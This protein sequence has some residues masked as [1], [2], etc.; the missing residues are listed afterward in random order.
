MSNRGRPRIELQLDRAAALVSKIGVGAA[1]EQLGVSRKTL[2]KCLDAAGFISAPI[3]T[4]KKKPE[5]STEKCDP[6][7]SCFECPFPDCIRP[8]PTGA[9]PTAGE[10][11]F[12]AI[13]KP[14]S[15][16]VQI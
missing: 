16:K 11:A 5:F 7:H 14:N 2:R 9:K 1:A 3:R 12:A 6:P 15:K 13:L 10:L 8:E 4:R